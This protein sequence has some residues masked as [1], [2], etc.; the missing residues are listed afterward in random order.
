MNVVWSSEAIDDLASLRI[1]ISESDPTAARRV[2][3]HT[4]HHIEFV[5]AENPDHGRVGRVAET[6]EA[7][8]PKTP[9]MEWLNRAK[10]NTSHII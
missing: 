8:A 7:I 4:L 6:R 2:A 5:L 1:N 9:L 10:V 3:P